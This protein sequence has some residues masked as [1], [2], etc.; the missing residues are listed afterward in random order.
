VGKDYLLGVDAGTSVM[1]VA[2]FDLEGHE[3]ESTSR[4]TTLDTSVPGRYETSMAGTW[5]TF[6]QTIRDLLQK[7]SVDGSQIAAIGLAGTMIGA[8][9][10]DAQGQPV[11][12]AILW[13]D[14]RTQPLINQ[15][16][17]AN[18]GFL[19][20]IF[21]L[22]GCVMET[23]CTLPLIRWLADHEPDSLARARHVFCS[24]DYLCFRLT[25]T[26]HI[27]PTEAAGL[28]G[29]TRTQS[30]DD[31]LFRLFGIGAYRHLFPPIRPSAAVVGEVLPAA[32]ES[33][34]LQ[35][36]TPVVAGA[37]DV[38]SNA[39][40]I[41]AVEPGIALTVLGTNCQSGL[42][43]DRPVFEPP[44]VGLLFCLPGQRWLRAL[45]NVAGTTNLNWFIE[46]FCAAEQ[47]AAPARAELYATIERLA[48]Q[49]EP[50][51]HGIIYHPYLSSVGVIAP[52]VES[53]A[54]A[55]FFGLTQQHRRADMLRAVYEG[56]V[57]A[58]RDCYS[59]L[60]TPI[61]EI[62]LAGGGARSRLW[63]QTLADC[64]GARVVIPEGSEFGAKGAALLAG[65]G[66]GL[67]KTAADASTSTF[68]V[69]RCFEPD[70]H[71]K[72]RYDAMYEIYRML[73]DE[74]RLAWRQSA[75]L[76]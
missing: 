11:R 33:T 73:R 66:I 74:V 75:N 41:G 51:A 36:G 3:Q 49:S 2:L 29:N 18:P 59:V 55:Q 69:A 17:A 67:F 13:C 20:E 46:Q 32:A 62:R 38:P 12:N 50:G 34:G 27:D 37:G 5:D 56:V 64:M 24:K 6:T 47:A 25:G 23:G 4:Q 54:R 53:A 22:D 30:Y 43:F 9:L 52:F 45:M 65:V 7:A 40:G 14:G 60:D 57:F 19:S 44:D 71:L 58:I 76:P 1:K 35:V 68:R 21:A 70:S 16:Q 72:P 26:V 61:R 31:R 15:M 42:I 8:W 63:S 48:E 39:L 28:P 10:I